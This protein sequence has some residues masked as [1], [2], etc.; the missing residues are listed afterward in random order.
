MESENKYGTGDF[1]RKVLER[2]ERISSLLPDKCEA[3]LGVDATIGYLRGPG[4]NTHSPWLIDHLLSVVERLMDD[5]PVYAVFTASFDHEYTRVNP[6]LF[7]LALTHGEDEAK[8]R[9]F[10][11]KKDLLDGARLGEDAEFSDQSAEPPGKAI[12]I[13]ADHPLKFERFDGLS[14]ATTGMVIAMKLERNKQYGNGS[15]A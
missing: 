7:S 13:D 12:V 3:G 14:L 5:R 2:L 10:E 1:D 9:Y 11:A 4:T 15:K 8:A 6:E